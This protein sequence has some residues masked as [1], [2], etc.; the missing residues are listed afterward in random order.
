MKTLRYILIIALLGEPFERQHAQVLDKE[1][2]TPR[3]QHNVHREYD[4]NGNLI[5]YDSSAITTWS[6]SS[7]NTEPDSVPDYWSYTPVVEDSINNEYLGSRHYG[8]RFPGDWPQV[9]LGIEFHDLDSIRRGFNYSFS[10]TPGDTADHPQDPYFDIYG[11]FPPMHPN[12]ESYIQDMQRMINDMFNR[13]EDMF[14]EFN[15]EEYPPVPPNNEGSDS[16]P[17]QPAPI[18]APQKYS[19]PVLNI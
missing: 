7:Y 10:L 3:S 2:T 15:E 1:N 5:E 4:E 17:E 9:D 19:R 11:R 16:I 13:Y 8:F 14:R 6:Y 12:I 18:V